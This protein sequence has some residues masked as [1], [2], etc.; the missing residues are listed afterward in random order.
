MID[1]MDLDKTH[2]HLITSTI[3]DVNLAI[4]EITE[5]HETFANISGIIHNDNN[6][7]KRKILITLSVFS[8]AQQIKMTWMKLRKMFRQFMIIN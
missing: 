7:N 5:A 2:A 1:A 8:L 6:R 3:Q 4:K